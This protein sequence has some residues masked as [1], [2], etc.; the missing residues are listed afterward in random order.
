MTEKRLQTRFDHGS[1]DSKGINPILWQETTQKS[2]NYVERAPSIA[3]K[4]E[5]LVSQMDPITAARIDQVLDEVEA[6]R[7]DDADEKENRTSNTDCRVRQVE[8]CGSGDLVSWM[9][10]YLGDYETYPDNSSMS[11]LCRP[12]KMH[13]PVSHLYPLE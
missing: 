11:S 5:E 2:S 9:R 10:Q 1:E 8:N 4:N 7:T 6:A 12:A 3:P 13:K